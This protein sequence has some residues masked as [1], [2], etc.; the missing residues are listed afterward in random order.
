MRILSAFALLLLA[1]ACSP[2]Q[3]QPKSTVFDPMIQT[4]QKAKQAEQALQAGAQ[5]EAQTIDQQTQ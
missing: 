1:A 4:E 2:E 5:R 3:N